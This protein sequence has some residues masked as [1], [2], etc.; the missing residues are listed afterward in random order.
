M[1]AEFA[2]EIERRRFDPRYQFR[3]NVTY[4]L[5]GYMAARYRQQREPAPE[6][7]KVRETRKKPVAVKIDATKGKGFK[8]PVR[9]WSARCSTCAGTGKIRDLAGV[10]IACPR[11]TTD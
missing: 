10:W 1:T 5:K 11:C 2:A 4:G 6:L 3:K 9:K 8:E 7:V